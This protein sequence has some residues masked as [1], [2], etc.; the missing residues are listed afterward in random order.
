VAI[1]ERAGESLAHLVPDIR[2]TAELVQEIADASREQNQGAQQVN[3]AIQQLDQTIQA[4][5]LAT[6]DMS[7]IAESLAVQARTMQESIG[8]FKV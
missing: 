8:F 6:S 7:Q 3:Q 1:A 5:A 4:N 2:R